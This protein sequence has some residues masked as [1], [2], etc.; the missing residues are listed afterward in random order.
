MDLRNLALTTISAL[1]LS[2]CGSSR[3]LQKDR[4]SGPIGYNFS[5]DEY[6][7]NDI[8][9]PRFRNAL[10]LRDYLE[11]GLDTLIPKVVEFY[12]DRFGEDLSP[13]DADIDF[14]NFW[15]FSSG[16]PV[17]RYDFDSHKLVLEYTPHHNADKYARMLSK[18]EDDWNSYE[19]AT[20]GLLPHEVAHWFHDNLLKEYGKDFSG[21]VMG[22]N[23]ALDRIKCMIVEGIAVYMAGFLDRDESY[24]GKDEYGSPIDSLMNGKPLYKWVYPAG[25]ELMRPILEKDFRN[26]IRLTSDNIPEVETVEDVKAYQLEILQ[27]LDEIGK[28]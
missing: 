3:Y 13:E 9:S 5:F 23:S 27:K 21:H 25:E 6:R 16:V 8:K 15:M 10:D 4:E 2:G 14:Q 24:I 18:D 12:N 22:E 7:E 28:K 11:T 1:L 26:G 19:A 17:F 20:F